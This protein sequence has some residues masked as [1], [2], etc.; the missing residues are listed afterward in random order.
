MAVCRVYLAI[1]LA[2]VGT[3]Q[4]TK[5]NKSKHKRVEHFAKIIMNLLLFIAPVGVCMCVRARSV[6]CVCVTLAISICRIVLSNLINHL[7][8]EE[9]SLVSNDG[10]L[11]PSVFYTIN[12]CCGS[13]TYKSVNVVSKRF[14][15][16]RKKNFYWIWCVKVTIVPANDTLNR[17]FHNWENGSLKQKS[18]IHTRT[19]WY[20]VTC[21]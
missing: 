1:Y 3:L 20:F 21:L 6:L 12:L 11:E 13:A 16:T 15:S 7:F 4:S 17:N 8:D 14:K 18:I 9:I 10:E 19:V 5:W 2:Y